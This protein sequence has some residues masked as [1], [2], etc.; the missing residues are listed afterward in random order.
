MFKHTDEDEDL[1]VETEEFAR[2][3]VLAFRVL[4]LRGTR[5]MHAGVY[6]NRVII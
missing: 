1:L 4:L 3:E 2:D 5:F 6:P